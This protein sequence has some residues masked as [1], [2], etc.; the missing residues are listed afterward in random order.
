MAIG[1]PYVTLAEMKAYA[2]IDDTDADT[3]I[4]SIIKSASRI[5]DDHCGRQFNDAGS[6]SARVFESIGAGLAMV[7][8]F[9]T[10]TGLIVETGPDSTTGYSTTI[11][12][13]DY[14]LLP[15]NGVVEHMPGYAYNRIKL[16]NT[17]S[18]CSSNGKPALRVT[19]RWGWA[20]V[21][22][23]VKDAT[24]IVGA[25]LFGRRYSPS[26]QPIAGAGDFMFRISSRDDPNATAA[27]S[28]YRFKIPPV[29]T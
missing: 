20:A 21:P 8:D 13:N 1:D 25:K 23:G 10:A 12:G 9:S 15:L 3:A 18:F 27:L 22:D 11:S 7:D 29:G 5:V 28:P 14:T 19:A 26:G 24:L 6:V 2:R 4:T 17:S 16:A